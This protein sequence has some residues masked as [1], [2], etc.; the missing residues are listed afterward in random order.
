PLL[1]DYAPQSLIEQGDPRALTARLLKAR[2]GDAIVV[3]GYP[4]ATAR[5]VALERGGAVEETATWH[6]IVSDQLWTLG[7]VESC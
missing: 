2:P 7:V 3:L 4:S 6:E 5:T 1:H